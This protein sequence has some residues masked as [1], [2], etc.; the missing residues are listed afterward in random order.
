MGGIFDGLGKLHRIFFSLVLIL[1]RGTGVHLWSLFRRLEKLKRSRDV[2][3]TN[4]ALVWDH[5]IGCDCVWPFTSDSVFLSSPL[6]L[7]CREL[8]SC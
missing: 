5:R 7:L 6:G 1:I 3:R 8:S 2:F 4:G